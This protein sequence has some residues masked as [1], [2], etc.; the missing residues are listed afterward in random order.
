MPCRPVPRNLS[1]KTRLFRGSRSSE[2]GG[3]REHCVILTRATRCLC[4]FRKPMQVTRALIRLVIRGVLRP[5]SRGDAP[6]RYLTA[7]G[8]ERMT[9]STLEPA[10][11]HRSPSDSSGVGIVGIVVG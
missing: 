6:A 8:A 4:T 11:D 1:L 5:L 9:L 7:V 2:P 3:R 10:S